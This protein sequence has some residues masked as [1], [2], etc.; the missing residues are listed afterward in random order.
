MQPSHT[1]E[2]W[3]YTKPRSFYPQECTTSTGST[4]PTGLLFTDHKTSF[5]QP[6]W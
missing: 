5:S 3:L 2:I 1:T 4:T 6:N